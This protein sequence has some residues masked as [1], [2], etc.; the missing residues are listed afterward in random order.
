V[1]EW[2]QGWQTTGSPIFLQ[3][4][5]D[6]FI[7]REAPMQAIETLRRVIAEADNDILPRFFLGRLYARLEMHD[8]A[9]KVLASIRDR[10]RESPTL[11]CLLGRLHE[12]REERTQAGRAYRASLELA[13]LMEDRYRCR[14]CGGDQSQWTAR[15]DSCG[16][17]NSIELHFEV[18]P[19]AGDD[20]DLDSR[21][22]P[23][24]PVHGE[25]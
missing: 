22:R 5:E 1:V 6:H 10:V 19:L 12:R 7:E 23:V 2:H 3:R 18:E 4:I 24:W 25:A 8:E 11:L 16:R 14:G 20:L 17:W 9:L 13:G 15:C 21:A